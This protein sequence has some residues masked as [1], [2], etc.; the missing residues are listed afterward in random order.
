MESIIPE[1]NIGYTIHA[2]DR[3]PYGVGWTTFNPNDTLRPEY[4][5]TDSK[6]LDSYPVWGRHALYIGGGYV[7]NV[8]ID[9]VEGVRM[10]MK[11]M[12]EEAWIDRYTRALFIEFSV[13]NAQTN[14]FSY[15]NLIEEIIPTGGLYPNHRFDILRL[16]PYH[17]GIG[18]VR[19]I[20]EAAYF[21]F[22]ICMFV[23][24]L[25]IVRKEGRAYFRQIWNWTEM[26]II[27]FSLTLMV[28]YFYRLYIVSVILEALAD[29]ER[30]QHVNL[31][32][33]AYWNLLLGY[34]LGLVLFLSNIKFLKLLRF[35]RRMGILSSTI[36]SCSIDLL[37]F[38][39]MFLSVF[40]AFAAV[41][42]L[43]FC[44]R[45][46]NYSDLL[47]TIET[48][49]TAVLGKFKFGEM[50]T[51]SI[52]GPFFFFCFTGY[53]CFV[54]INVF[55]TIIIGAFQTIKGDIAKQSND[56]EIVDFILNR[57]KSWTGT[58]SKKKEDN[59]LPN[60]DMKDITSSLPDKVDQLMNHIARVYF[61]QGTFNNF[62]KE[63]AVEN[64][65]KEKK[66]KK[67]QNRKIY[68]T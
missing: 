11:K 29:A 66:K 52:L 68:T 28:I 63:M 65:K 8:D 18:L 17:E 56:Y 53:V 2:E 62:V 47:F 34:M 40:F 49:I 25:M 50:M 9:S 45:L 39:F 46:R 43:I 1:C 48:M 60:L 4:T 67:K 38:F 30:Q 51:E 44:H 22:I 27:G 64:E 32:Y 20:C 59:L 57:F 6:K 7:Y 41:F 54:M 26:F 55:L 5:F 36:R 61:D 23:K 21:V 14:L 16:L 42:Y 24:E 13:Y 31:Q 58:G 35:N 37:N 15:I 10:T 33:V 12:Y 3:A 19:L